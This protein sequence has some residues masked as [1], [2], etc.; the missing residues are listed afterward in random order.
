MELMNYAIHKETHNI[1]CYG[2]SSIY[3][4]FRL[5]LND[6]VVCISAETFYR[7]YIPI[8]DHMDG[9]EFFKVLLLLIDE[10]YSLTRIPSNRDYVNEDLLIIQNQD[11]VIFM[12]RNKNTGYITVSCTMSQYHTPN[13]IGV[14]NILKEEG[15]I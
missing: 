15:V 14:F 7:E 1:I 4:S 10:K 3:N 12:M 8:D 2:A 11:K 5:T 6:E 9:Y 13:Y